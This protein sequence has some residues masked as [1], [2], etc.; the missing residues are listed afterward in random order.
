MEMGKSSWNL[1]N[2]EPALKRIA[3][4]PVTQSTLQR[5]KITD[6]AKDL[7]PDTLNI[8]WSAPEPSILY[9]QMNGSGK[10]RLL[11]GFHITIYLPPHADHTS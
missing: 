8:L 1:A 9:N 7:Y 6:S 2:S 3:T 11:Q 10:P 4:S 5:R